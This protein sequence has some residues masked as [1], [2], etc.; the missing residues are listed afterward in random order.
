MNYFDTTLIPELLEAGLLVA[1]LAYLFWSRKNN[2]AQGLAEPFGEYPGLK[3]EYDKFIPSIRIGSTH[4]ITGPQ[5]RRT[6]KR[7]SQQR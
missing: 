6:D 4:S 5:S 3:T 1:V 7:K 2:R